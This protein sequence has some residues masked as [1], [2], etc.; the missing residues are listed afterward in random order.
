MHRRC[1]VDCLTHEWGKEWELRTHAF[2]VDVREIYNP[3]GVSRYLGKYLVKGF[4]SREDLVKLGFLRRWS[5]SRNWPRFGDLCLRGTDEKV[6]DSIQIIP[7]WFRRKEMEEREAF[8]R[9][10]YYLESVGTPA[11]VGLA[12]KRKK[13]AMKMKIERIVNEVLSTYPSASDGGSRG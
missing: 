13:R 10:A 5:S 6:W 7:R 12:K 2:V 3:D 1:L 9:G 11:A 4:G 8:G